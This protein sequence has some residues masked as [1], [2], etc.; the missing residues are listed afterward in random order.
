MFQSPQWGNNSKAALYAKLVGAK[1]FQSPQWGNNSKD[2]WQVR[3]NTG[4]GFQSP[5]WGNNS[6]GTLHPLNLRSLLKTVSVPSMGK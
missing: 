6:K 4:K 1:G 5:Q 2:F 3:T